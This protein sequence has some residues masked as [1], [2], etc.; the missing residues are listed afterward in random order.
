MSK[1]LTKEKKSDIKMAPTLSWFFSIN[2]KLLVLLSNRVRQLKDSYIFHLV[3]KIKNCL[4][5]LQSPLKLPH[6]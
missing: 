2:C 1:Q 5:T 3:K 4:V 6:T